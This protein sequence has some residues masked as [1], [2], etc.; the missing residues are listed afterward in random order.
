MAHPAIA[1]LLKSFYRSLTITLLFSEQI[2][3]GTVDQSEAQN[4]FVL[5]PYINTAKKQKSLGV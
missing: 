3:R 2:K 1:V 4:E 5:R